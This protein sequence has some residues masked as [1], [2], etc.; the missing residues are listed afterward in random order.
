MNA[1]DLAVLMQFVPKARWVR[2]SGTPS[3]GVRAQQLESRAWTHDSRWYKISA[4]LDHCNDDAK[5]SQ[6]SVR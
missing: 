1:L 6:K 3:C 4:P 5:I 2:L